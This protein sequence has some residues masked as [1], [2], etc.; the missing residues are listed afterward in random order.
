MRLKQLIT[1]L[2]ILI[3]G[4]A[5]GLFIDGQRTSVGG[6][7]IQAAIFGVISAIGAITYAALALKQKFDTESVVHQAG[8]AYVAWTLFAVLYGLRSLQV[9]QFAIVIGVGLLVSIFIGY[10][11]VH[12]DA[13]AP[14]YERL[15]ALITFEWFLVLSFASASFLV[16]GALVAVLSVVTGIIFELLRV[17]QATQRTIT[18]ALAMAGLILLIFITGFR[19]TL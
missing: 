12:N 4:C 13:D 6:L 11:W 14:S 8:V 5:L 7:S 18:S 3:S 17:G 10:L 15:L 16:L 19:W 1:A 2:S 9:T